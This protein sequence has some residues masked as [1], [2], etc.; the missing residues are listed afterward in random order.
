MSSDKFVDSVTKHDFTSPL[1]PIVSISVGSVRWKSK[2]EK[3]S[4][5]VLV[6]ELV[7][8]V[9]SA[10]K[11]WAEK[12]LS[13][14]DPYPPA[15]VASSLAS[16]S[17]GPLGGHLEWLTQLICFL[18]ALNPKILRR[19]LLRVVTVTTLVKAPAAQRALPKSMSLP[20]AGTS[21][22][23]VGL[24]F[25]CWR[26]TCLLSLLGGSFQAAMRKFSLLHI[27]W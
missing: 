6:L 24:D 20:F 18:P 5:M 11:Q 17:L 2:P 21:C 25:A 9:P 19:W 16:A 27:P 8:L 12:F 7:P 23:R 4:L 10:S 22:H 1:S 3:E 13:S 15:I 14:P 26:G